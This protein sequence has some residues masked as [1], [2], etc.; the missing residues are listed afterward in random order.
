M[1]DKQISTYP[2]QIV[3]RATPAELLTQVQAELGEGIEPFIFSAEIS[4]NRLDAYY[5]YMGETSLR[6]YADDAQAG[7]SF[8]DSHSQTRL[9]FG[10][11]LTGTFEINDNVSRVVA[12]F[13][14]VPGVEFG[15]MHSYKSTDD[16]IRAVKARLVRDVSIGFYGGKE[17]CNV[18][19][20][21]VWEW[22]KQDACPHIPGLE[23]PI[24]DRGEQTILATFTVEG[25]HLAEV[26]AVFDGATPEAMILKA[27]HQIETGKLQA[28]AARLLETRYR[29]KLPDAGRQAW[30]GVDINGKGGEGSKGQKIMTEPKQAESK[31]PLAEVQKTLVSIR[32]VLDNATV[33]IPDGDELERVC[34]LITERERLTTEVARQADEVKRL[35]PLADDGAK[36]RADLI[37]DTLA[38][39]VRVMGDSFPEETYKGMLENGTS[40]EAIKKMR[41]AFAEQAKTRLPGGR[42]TVD[43]DELQQPQKLER[44]TPNLA[45]AA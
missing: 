8:Q 37:S 17:L 2:A 16:F 10:Q 6:N 18:C 23:Y 40:I 27:R 3:Y 22:W 7:V 34:F 25:A 4:S 42:Q 35:Q 28:Q 30:S 11:S 36:Y 45:Y 32:G 13:Y 24:G 44:E 15:G 20:K 19:G 26:S 5:G 1:S 43:E 31:E 39:G 41:D 38:E 29:I 21:P 12:E 14:T 33:A 9:G